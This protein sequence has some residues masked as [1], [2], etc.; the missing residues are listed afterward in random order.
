MD[1]DILAREKVPTNYQSVESYLQV[2]ADI[3]TRY[4]DRG[5]EIAISTNG[6]MCPDGNTYR[7]Y[8]M[9][10]LQGVNLKQEMEQRTGL[11]V[12]V[13][14][15]GFSAALGEWW[16]GA[17]QGTRNLLVIV[18]GSG[19]GGGII[20]DGKLYQGSKL[21]AAMVF[22]MLSSY[23]KEHSDLAGLTTSFALLLYQLS[24]IKQ[25]PVEEMTGDRFFDY[26]AAGD[27]VAT[28]M[29]EAYSEHIA[30]VI[31]NCSLLLDPDQ[32]VL[33]GGLSARDILIDLINR[34]L[35]EIPVRIMQGQVAELL[36]MVAA[37]ASDFD[38]QV[39]RGALAL[40][41]NIYG[42][43]YHLLHKTNI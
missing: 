19:M 37:D 1:G 4:R 40:D 30:S 18:L 42:A 12:T 9:R 41:S 5:D 43:L 6:R 11:P 21:N 10:F 15:D 34:K 14:N 28:G 16:R 29:L 13:I 8:T 33:T 39:K 31:Y 2:L 26:V 32:V 17:G 38:I 23:D 35:C 27:P 24:A 20:I 22:G 3:V 36:E 25:I 7:A